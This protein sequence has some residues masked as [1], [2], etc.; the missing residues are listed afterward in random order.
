MDMHQLT[1]FPLFSDMAPDLLTAIANIG[2][3]IP[4]A[5]QETIFRMNEP[6]RHL[7]GVLDGEV[8][9]TLV[10][11]ERKL[12]TD[13]EYEE[14]IVTSTELLERE[15]GVDAISPGE[16]FGWSSLI[17]GGRWT[18]RARCIEAGQ[19]FS[20]SAQSLVHLFEKDTA[21]GYRFMRRI[22]EIISKRLQKRTTRL[23]EAWGEAFE[24]S[25]M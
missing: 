9:L 8:A 11:N 24:V 6:A 12:K 3:I 16:I 5:A 23:I 7:Y 10:F 2:E 25:G 22:N 14:A 17:K 19:I 15:I 21:T 18:S 20:L 13:I 4:M 1:S